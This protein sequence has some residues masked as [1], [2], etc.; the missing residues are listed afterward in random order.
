MSTMIQR[1]VTVN[2]TIILECAMCRAAVT[3]KDDPALTN[4]NV[5]IAITG[6]YFGQDEE[7]SRVLDEQL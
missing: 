7:L 5:L 2:R 3:S 4:L 1:S 6:G